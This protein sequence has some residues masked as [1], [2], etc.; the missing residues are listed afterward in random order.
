[1]FLGS[2]G[3]TIFINVGT[4]WKAERMIRITEF[5]VLKIIMDVPI[6]L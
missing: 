5:V 3:T 6:I 2:N 1:M 4:V